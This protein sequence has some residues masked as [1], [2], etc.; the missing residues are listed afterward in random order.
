MRSLAPKH[1]V[2]LP[3]GILGG[4]QLARMLALKGAEL[5]LEVHVLSEQEADPAAQ[6][7]RH[8][9]RGDPNNLEDLK[10][11]F[12]KVKLVTFESEFYS[13]D[14]LSQAALAVP[15]PIY[16]DPLVMGRL[17]DRLSQ[18]ECLI[19]SQV[20]TAPFVAVQNEAELKSA[21]QNFNGKCVLKKRR[22]GYDGYGNFVI[23]NES[24]LNHALQ[25]ISFVV[26]SYIV[27]EYIPFHRELAVMLARNHEG[28]CVHFP[29]VETRQQGGRCDWV[30]GPV[31]HPRFQA[32]L[33]SLSLMLSKI[34]YVGVVGIELFDTGKELMVNEM[35][36]RVHNSGHYSLD[37]LSLDQFTLHWLSVLDFKLSLPAVLKPAFV[38]TNLIGSSS[39]DPIFPHDLTGRLHW[40]G[41]KQ[42]RQSRKM[43][44]INYV[45]SDTESLLTTALSERSKIEN[46]QRG[47]A[48]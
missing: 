21:F 41:K 39:E 36:P 38:M 9:H 11:F 17:Q 23:K 27:E 14:L 43:G 7:V 24:D 26:D 13:G 18:K 47:E 8:W 28:Q 30:K 5:G 10:K 45:G 12:S 44:H 22:G 33:L 19:E 34:N 31:E 2:G 29:L 46:V 42:N 20:A 4:G 15:T 3:V 1:S 37:A 16:P 32:L 25:K 40:Y 48:P 6:V 35:A